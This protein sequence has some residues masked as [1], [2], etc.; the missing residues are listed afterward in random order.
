MSRLASPHA[1]CAPVGFATGKKP[2]SSFFLRALQAAFWELVAR[3]SRHGL[4]GQA[5]PALLFH[6]ITLES[7]GTPRGAPLFFKGPL[8]LR[9]EDVKEPYENRRPLHSWMCWFWHRL[10]CSWQKPTTGLPTP[11]AQTVSAEENSYTSHAGS[12]QGAENFQPMR[13]WEG[14]S[15]NRQ[16]LYPVSSHL[17]ARWPS[18]RSGWD[19]ST[20]TH[21]QGYPVPWLRRHRAVQ[22]QARA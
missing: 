11:P 2:L 7:R 15:G 4:L 14:P 12:Q 8:S 10:L 20:C 6:T 17:S 9:A 13:R 21:V 19:T 1:R 5:S 16:G 3:T 18:G 22:A